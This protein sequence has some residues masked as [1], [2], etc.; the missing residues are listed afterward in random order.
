MANLLTLPEIF[1]F[2]LIGLMVIMAFAI[3][4]GSAWWILKGLVDDLQKERDYYMNLLE[5][6]LNDG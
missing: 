3:G 1:R 2:F 4:A 5:K 6:A